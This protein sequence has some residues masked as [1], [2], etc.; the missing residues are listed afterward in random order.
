MNRYSKSGR[1]F[2]N[3]EIHTIINIVIPKSFHFVTFLQNADFI[4][5]LYIMSYLIAFV[6]SFDNSTNCW[7]KQKQNTTRCQISR[8]VCSALNWYGE[9]GKPKE[10]V[11][12]EF[13]LELQKDNL[14]QLPPPRK[15]S[16]NRFIKKNIIISYTPPTNPLIGTLKN[17]SKPKIKRVLNRNDNNLWEYFMKKY[18]Y[19]G[20]KG[21]VGRFLKYLITID[22]EMV[23]CLGFTGAAL[24]VADRD[25]FPGWKDNQRVNN[26]KHIAN[27]FRFLILP[28][29]KIKYLA[30]HILAKSV[31]V[32]VK[33]WKSEYNVEIKYLET[34]VEQDRFSGTCYKAANWKKIGQTKGYSKTKKAYKKNNKIKDIYL[35]DLVNR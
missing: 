9:N 24:K 18:H 4:S 31:S 13:L 22:N 34:F 32:V 5:C 27:N 19:L 10:W 29:V 3:N 26:I 14:I 20:Y 11:C 23:A 7:Y 21:Q 30:S 28:W 8:A 17:F 25:C 2:S 1:S 12:R 16:Q 15:Y 35:Y 33:D 6:Y